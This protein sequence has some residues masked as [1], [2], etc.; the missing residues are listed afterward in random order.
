MV[1]GSRWVYGLGPGRFASGDTAASFAR[2]PRNSTRKRYSEAGARLA[3]LA[4]SWPDRGKVSYW[5]GT[6]E[7]LEG[8]SAQALE[9][10]G[11]VPDEAPEAPVAALARARLAI[12][13]NRYGLAEACLKRA[14]TGP[15]EV[16]DEAWRLLG[17]V[18]WVTGR[19]DAYR[20]LLQRDAERTA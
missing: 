9:T 10:W 8:H 4:Q 13:L 15:S 19:R 11:R 20:H 3:R 18:Y 1:W 17:R 2:Q 12:D 14:T 16:S 5:L 6:C 7:L